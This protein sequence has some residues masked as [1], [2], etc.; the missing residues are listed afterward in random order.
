[1]V[2][3]AIKAGNTAVITGAG[4]GGIGYALAS[5]FASHKMRLALIDNSSSD[6]SKASSEL[7]L[8][9][10]DILTIEADVSKYED[11][12]DAAKKVKEKF[13]E[14][15]ISVLCLNAG[16]GE[17]GATTWNGKVDTWTKTLGV[18][19]FGVINGSNAF[20]GS[21]VESQNPGLVIVTGSKQ[22][23][24]APPG[25]G[26]YYNVSKAGV[27]TFTE[28]M[29]H[30]LRE[31]TQKR[32]TAHL[33]VPGWTFTKLTKGSNT[34]KP[35]GAWE[36]QQVVDYALPRIEKGDFYIICPDNETSE[37]MDQARMEWSSSDVAQNRSALSR[38][39]KEYKDDFEAFM[40]QRVG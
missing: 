34:E 23:I 15:S 12:L 1:M 37:Q 4:Y 16:V 35:A 18:N 38:W 25:T 2:H 31:A 14:K 19:L 5:T 9:G 20:T 17:S 8:P 6:L 33:L 21:L 32:V 24:T 28:R 30:E 26:A 22:G 39:D 3:P 10:D 13:G 36:P 11:M 29:A 27:K 7:K 40:K